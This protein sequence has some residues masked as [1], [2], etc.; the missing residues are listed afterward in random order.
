M[1]TFVDV[2]NTCAAIFTKRYH[3]ISSHGYSMSVFLLTLYF[4]IIAKESRKT[5]AF[6]VDAGTAILARRN[7][8]LNCAKRHK[9]E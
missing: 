8:F 1:A 5:A 9:D 3:M 6:V 4:T 2:L 7:T